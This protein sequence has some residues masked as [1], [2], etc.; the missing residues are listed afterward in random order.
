MRLRMILQGNIFITLHFNSFSNLL[1][2]KLF[3]RKV[4]RSIVV[5]LCLGQ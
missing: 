4:T 3:A 1:F 2:M 5:I